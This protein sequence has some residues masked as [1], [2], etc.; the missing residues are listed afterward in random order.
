MCVRAKSRMG[1]GVAESVLGA[2]D[3]PRLTRAVATECRRWCRVTSAMPAWWWLV[4]RA[5]GRTTAPTRWSSP[6]SH[7]RGRVRTA[8]ARTAPTRTV[9]A[10]PPY[11]TATDRYWSDRGSTGAPG[12]SWSGRSHRPTRPARSARPARPGRPDAARP[13]PH[14]GRHCPRPTGSTAE[15]ARPGAGPPTHDNPDHRRSQAPGRRPAARHGAA[16]PAPAPPE[17]ADGSVAAAARAPGLRSRNDPPPR[18][19]FI[20]PGLPHP[21]PDRVRQVRRAAARRRPT[22]DGAIPTGR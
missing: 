7:G 6:G 8:T 4:A 10:T 13:T 3:V 11:W 19:L 16:R 5:F 1:V 22:A 15:P 17:H 12:R 20:H 21:R 9:T 14:D 2:Q 18:G